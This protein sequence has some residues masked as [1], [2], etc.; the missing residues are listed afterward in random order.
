VAEE[1]RQ[2]PETPLE[3]GA[4]PPGELTRIEAHLAEIRAQLEHGARE[5]RYEEFSAARYISAI[6]Q[7][8]TVALLAWALSDWIFGFAVDQILVKLGFATV[9]QLFSL[10]AAILARRD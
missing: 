2:P 4:E 9:I 6:G 3:P 10:T 8:L 1:P 5:E 7:A